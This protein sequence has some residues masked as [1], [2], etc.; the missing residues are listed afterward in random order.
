MTETAQEYW[1][2]PEQ[3]IPAAETGSSAGGSGT[4]GETVPPVEPGLRREGASAVS[5]N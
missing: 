4:A 1:H 5:P 3:T 2:A